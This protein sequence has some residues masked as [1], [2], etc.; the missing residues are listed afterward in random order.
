MDPV[1]VMRLAAAMG[2]SC[3]RLLLVGCETTPFHEEDDMSGGLSDPVRAAV[4]QRP[5]CSSSRSPRTLLGVK[6]SE[7]VETTSLIL[8]RSVHA[9]IR[10]RTSGDFVA[11]VA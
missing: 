2:G 9:E 8:R 3:G 5:W 4:E 11:A 10:I 7:L 6:E 1:K